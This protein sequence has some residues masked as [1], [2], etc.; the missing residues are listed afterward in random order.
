MGGAEMI[1]DNK[2][3]ISELEDQL[4][5]TRVTQINDERALENLNRTVENLIHESMTSSGNQKNTESSDQEVNRRLAE[6]E[7]DVR[8]IKASENDELDE[9]YD[10]LLEAKKEQNSKI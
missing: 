8:K 5:Q 3:K 9:L 7:E 1:N 10:S 2:R 4:V 6:L